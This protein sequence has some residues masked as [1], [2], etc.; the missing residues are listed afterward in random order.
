MHDVG[1]SLNAEHE[2]LL[3]ILNI[4]TANLQESISCAFFIFSFPFLLIG[5]ENGFL[6]EQAFTKKS[7]ASSVDEALEDVGPQLVLPVGPVDSFFFLL[8]ELQRSQKL[9]LILEDVVIHGLVPLLLFHLHQV[10]SKNII[11]VLLNIIDL[12]SIDRRDNI[13]HFLRKSER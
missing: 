2:S 7:V 6:A 4:L 5:V 8:H 9:K 3:D 1:A 13:L 12:H 10:H 11:Q